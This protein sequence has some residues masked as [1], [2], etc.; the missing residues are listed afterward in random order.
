MTA[1][2]DVGR[3]L[4][5]GPWTLYQKRL[6]SLAALAIIFDGFDIQIL[7]FAI[8]SLM[9]EWHVARAAF[10]PVLALGLAGMAIGSAVA[11][12]FGDRY[13]RRPALIGC[14]TLFGLATVATAFVNSLAALAAL[15]FITGMGAGGA[16]P[17]ASTLAAE[18]AP[19]RMRSTAVKL[20]IVCIPL[21]GMLGGMIAARVLPAYGWRTLYEIGGA[22]PLGFA[23]ILWLA[24]SESPRFLA[25]RPGSWPALRQ[26]L[27]R[28]DRLVPADGAF[29]DRTERKTGNRAS[30]RALFGPALVRDTAGLWIAFFF[31]LGSI[32]LV[33]GWLPTMLAAQGL[34]VATASQGL[35]VYNFGGVLGVLLWAALITAL[36]SRGPMLWGALGDA[37]SAL[38]IL[39]APMHAHGDRTLLLMA[40]GLNGLLANAVQTAMFALAAHVYPTGIRA[41]G[42]AT[43]AAMGR[44][45]GILSSLTGAAIIG[46]GVGA[47]WGG[48][49]A[50]MVCSF[51]GLALVR[52]H[53]PRVEKTKPLELLDDEFTSDL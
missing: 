53:C 48:L 1:A 20:T 13:G 27:V 43:A 52:N 47:Y 32:Y 24:L 30:I 31:C 42:V 33:F 23:L 19:I 3:L 34:D 29:E 50:A 45:G 11:G 7:G 46:A 5:R 15:R 22:L 10:A 51:G 28:M 8:P 14:I 36:G 40:V 4:G 25:Q 41:S 49:A 26:L 38:A 37:V 17:N 2:I 21:G 6:T 12:Y 18:F 35:A 16:V 44:V 9:G 39:L